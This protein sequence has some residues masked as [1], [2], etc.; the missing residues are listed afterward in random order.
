MS[1]LLRVVFLFAI[2]LLVA[3][4]AA[5]LCLPK[6]Y[7]RHVG[8][9][10]SDSSCTDND[11]QTAINNS[12]CPNTVITITHEHTY[13][14]QALDINGKVNL[15]LVGAA[16][17]ASCAS[18]PPTCDPQVGCGG[19]GGGAPPAPNLTIS[20]NGAASVVYIHGNSSVTLESLRLTGGGGTAYGG[21]VHFSGS[22]ALTIVNSTIDY[23]SATS[24]GG[25]IQFNGSGGNAT[26]TLGAGTLIDENSS[27]GDGGGIHVNGSARLLALQPYTFIAY[28]QAGGHGG[29]LYVAGPARA[30]IASPGF[31]GAPVISYN[32]AAYGG[33]I[34][35]DAAPAN[36]NATVR[37]FSTDAHNP[38]Q[39]SDNRAS[40][41]GGGIWMHPYISGVSNTDVYPVLCAFDFR[42]DNNIAQE[43][44]AIYSDTDSSVGNGNVGGVVYL[45]RDD[46]FNTCSTPE[47]TASLNGVA[48][49]A[50]VACNTLNGGVAEDN[51][52]DPKP[53]AVILI[54][55][56]GTLSGER[57]VMRG[58]TGGHAI[59][60]FDSGVGIGN[61]LIADNGDAGEVI[62]MENDNNDQFSNLAIV[63]CTIV[64]NTVG[65]GAVIH[66]PYPLQ[67]ADSI[68]DETGIATLDYTGSAP[69]L[70]VS[71]VLA[72]DTST[73][74]SAAGID[75]G[76]PDYV[77]AANSNYHLKATSIGIDFAPANGGIDLDGNARDVDLTSVP[78]NY[79]PRD[80]G[81]YELQY[82]CAP[83]T[84][85][86][87]GFE[88]FQ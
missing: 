75:Q 31:N 52:N 35:I 25:G 14:S 65:S 53:G 36:A 32:S 19:G 45:N 6:Y 48:C 51:A 34:G 37:L 4:D 16:D 38:V 70:T 73:L 5:G 49:A 41:T 12:T 88:T 26:L 40:A 77:D 24:Q 62:R 83:D 74:P 61:C 27:S 63:N 56:E 60:A 72:T 69:G 55:D 79:G 67:L 87:N 3:A 46:G 84:V 81:A 50:G 44:T 11:I 59:R 18:S 57:F 82:V 78:N 39:V 29:G 30:D 8:N 2:W 15:I 86:C 10:A 9:T 66:S 64:N 17:G 71:Y 85:F 68:I 28:N 1:T 80:I 21:G 54:Q 42:I 58:N 22:G 23:N 13:T 33:G 76:Q 47:T 7:Y 43:G 20:G